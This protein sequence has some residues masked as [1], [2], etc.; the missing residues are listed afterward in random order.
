LDAGSHPENA[1]III[2]G[3]KKGGE[4]RKKMFWKNSKQETKKKIETGD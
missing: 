4:I 1:P 2:F 3:K